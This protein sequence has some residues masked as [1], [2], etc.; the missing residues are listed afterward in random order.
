MDMALIHTLNAFVLAALLV[1]AL[2][3]S[4]KALITIFSPTVAATTAETRPLTLEA[5]SQAHPS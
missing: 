4:A 2:L 3:I 5:P 1:S